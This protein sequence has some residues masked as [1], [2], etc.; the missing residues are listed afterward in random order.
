MDDI[1][2]RTLA[3]I[4]DQRSSEI[5]KANLSGRRAF[6]RLLDIHVLDPAMG[7][8]HFLVSAAAYVARRIAN[9]PSYDADLSLPELQGLIAERCLYGVDVNPMAV[10]IARLALWLS[11]VRSDQ[12]LRFLANLRHGNSLVSCD[13][14]TL[15]DEEKDLFAPEL[16]A[17]AR[18]MLDRIGAIAS[19]DTTTGQ[20]AHEKERIQGE[21]DSLKAPLLSVCDQAVIPPVGPSAGRPLHWQIEYPERFLDPSGTPLSDGGFDA[22][23]GNPPYVRIQELGRDVAEYCRARYETAT[24]SFDAFVPFIERGVSLLRPRGRLGFIVPSAFLKL[25]YGA[26]LRAR[27]AERSLVE[28]IIDFGHAQVFE[29]ATNYTCIV[30]LEREGDNDLSYVAVRGSS[31]EVRRAVA[32]HALPAAEHYRASELGEAPWILLPRDEREILD[33]MRA[34]GPPLS[35]ATR[36]IFQG[37]ITGADPIYIVEDRGTRG[38]CRVV[39]TKAGSE[40][41][42]E[43]DLLHPLASGSDV[44]R[45]ALRTLKSLLLF[46]Y[47]RDKDDMRLVSEEELQA[48]PLTWGYLCAN[49]AELR[50]RERGKMDHDGWW[51]FGR[52]QSLGLHDQP[53]LGVAATVKRLEVAADPAG[54]AYFHNVRVNGI[55]PRD[56]GPSLPVLTAVLNSRAIDF[57]FRRGAAPLQNDFY[58]AN[59]QFIAWLPVPTELPGD[60]EVAGARLHELVALAESERSGFLDWL[61]STWI[62]RIGWC[63]SVR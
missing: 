42:L 40:L 55:L 4:L 39:A 16:A 51:A 45:Y 27:L 12:P 47:R 36:Q 17:R 50:R 46:P 44:E 18:E 21:L 37:L 5:A 30:V 19:M 8:G 58:T 61:S 59:K 63:G 29:A 13:L 32:T 41:E 60:L 10:E 28:E 6:N 35:D 34:A 33:T 62:H 3:P 23:I 57:A 54:A 25:E 38:S 20:Q 11:T 43:P 1:V 26:R 31:D 56:D 15:L 2:E 53:K 14:S 48:L 52:T 22:V 49:E 7:S 9:D 24:G